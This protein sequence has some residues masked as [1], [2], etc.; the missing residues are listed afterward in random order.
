MLMRIKHTIFR[1]SFLHKMKVHKLFF[2]K[3]LHE[4]K[5][6]GKN[7]KDTTNKNILRCQY[8]RK[9]LNLSFKKATK[10]SQKKKKKGHP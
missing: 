10:L 1:L 6:K 7:I 5:K 2:F 4:E 3:K 8:A 9:I